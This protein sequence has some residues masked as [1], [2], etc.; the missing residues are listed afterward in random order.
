[1]QRSSNAVQSARVDTL[2]HVTEPTMI[3]RKIYKM[4]KHLKEGLARKEFKIKKVIK[5]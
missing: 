3:I 1:M 4:N 5:E 2:T